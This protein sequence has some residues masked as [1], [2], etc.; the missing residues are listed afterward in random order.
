MAS[1]AV[2]AC[3]AA[4]GY[5]TGTPVRRLTPLRAVLTA[6]GVDYLPVGLWLAGDTADAWQI[7]M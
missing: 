7:A 5:E 4:F 6:A 1:R 2:Q 3:A